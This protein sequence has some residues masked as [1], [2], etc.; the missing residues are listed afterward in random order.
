M[1]FVHERQPPTDGTCSVCCS[2]GRVWRFAEE[3]L[4]RVGRYTLVVGEA[5]CQPC[6]DMIVDEALADEDNNAASL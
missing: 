2:D 1:P 4:P 3:P 5:L 6:L